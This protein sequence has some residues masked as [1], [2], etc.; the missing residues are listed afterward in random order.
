MR[1]PPDQGLT[2]P[3]HELPPRWG[4]YCSRLWPLNF[5]GGRSQCPAHQGDEV[6]G[7]LA[8]SWFRHQF[9]PS[10]PRLR[11]PGVLNADLGHLSL[12]PEYGEVDLG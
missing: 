5:A 7:G 11:R 8:S 12:I 4:F 9:P 10:F 1:G 3:G 2:P 6:R